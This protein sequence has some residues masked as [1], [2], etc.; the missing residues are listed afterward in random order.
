M[1]RYLNYPILLF[2]VLIMSLECRA[3]WQA[4][5]GLEGADISQVLVYDSMMFISGT[6]NGIFR[7]NINDSEW[8]SERYEGC[9]LQLRIIDSVLFAA[10][11][12][13][14]SFLRS[15]DLG[16]TWEDVPI[17]KN[18]WNYMEVAND[19]LFVLDDEY[20]GDL[21]A[22][23]NYGDDWQ[24]AFESSVE[25]S[26]SRI[27]SSGNCL[28]GESYDVDSLLVVSIDAGYNWDTI[29]LNY[30]GGTLGNFIASFAFFN[31]TLFVC[32]GHYANQFR[33]YYYDELLDYW[34]CFNDT[35]NIIYVYDFI[36]HNDSLYACSF[37]GFYW[38]NTHD[39]VLEAQNNGLGIQ[40]VE[41][42]FSY[43]DRMYIATESGPYFREGK[44][45]WQFDGRSLYQLD[46][47]QIIFQD[48]TIFALNDKMMYYSTDVQ[49][50]FDSLGTEWIVTPHYIKTTDSL[51]YA[52]SDSGF[53]ISENSGYSW[54]YYNDGI[55]TNSKR[56]NDVGVNS[57]YCFGCRSGLYRAHKDT[58]FFRRLPNSIGNANVW[59]IA[60]LDSVVLA[61]V[62]CDGTYR[63]TDNG[64]TFEHIPET[65]AGIF[66]F[67]YIDQVLYMYD[68][69]L[70][71][72]S[73]DLGENWSQYQEVNTITIQSM[74][75]INETAVYGCQATYNMAMDVFVYS[76]LYPSG[77]LINEN[78]PVNSWS[79]VNDVKFYEESILL[80][81]NSNSIWYRNDLAV[82]LPEEKSMNDISVNFFPN[83]SEGYV[84]CSCEYSDYE[85]NLFTTEGRL[86]QSFSIKGNRTL[87]DLSQY[88]SGVYIVRINTGKR[89]Y[90]EKLIIH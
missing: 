69:N 89:S 34:H 1:P 76:P 84:N 27:H 56:V 15:F 50:G 60:V 39:K 14:N 43:E 81:Y 3:Q 54:T 40:R 82:S 38:V 29:S 55:S 77:Y 21:Y 35:L 4:C 16:D 20:N 7:K 23:D 86:L 30:D 49:I 73:T 63:S 36:T 19:R 10:Y 88:N 53:M 31:D 17:P 26:I 66:Q 6:G 59:Y 42:A 64:N 5:Q 25:F 85:I 58:L 51:W 79:V 62:Y 24:I 9:Y 52:G 65:G 46:I 80:S 70:V 90:S 41:S 87:L 28:I 78:L 45:L 67:R 18:Y 11:S 72:Y 48:D 57:K 2:F 74:D 8:S 22:S 33:I 12:W 71:Y 68:Y 75:L 37:D 32:N 44:S 83:P 61:S 13:Q 47:E